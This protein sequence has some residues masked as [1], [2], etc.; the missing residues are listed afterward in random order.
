MVGMAQITSN[1]DIELLNQI[2][3]HASKSGKLAIIDLSMRE[4]VIFSLTECACF[5]VPLIYMC[6]RACVCVLLS[7]LKPIVSLFLHN[8]IFI[9]SPCVVSCFLPSHIIPYS[10]LYF[11]S[12]HFLILSYF[13]YFFPILTFKA[14]NGVDFFSHHEKQKGCTPLLSGVLFYRREVINE[15]QSRLLFLSKIKI[16]END[17][18]RCFP[19]NIMILFLSFQFLLLLLFFFRMRAPLG[20]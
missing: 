5:C 12:S 4:K 9:A 8:F 16:Y 2:R 11:L 3:S 17:S 18:C 1:E 7:F 10:A 19:A 13:S 20:R 15:Q 14:V 6:V